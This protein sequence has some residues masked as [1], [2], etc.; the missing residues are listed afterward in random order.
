M[1]FPADPIGPHHRQGVGSRPRCT[2]LQQQALLPGVGTG[3]G[4]QVHVQ[5]FGYIADDQNHQD[6]PD[7]IGQGVP[8]ADVFDHL[9]SGGLTQ[10]WHQT[11]SHRILSGR[12]GRRAGERPRHQASIEA[13]GKIENTRQRKGQPQ[14]DQ[15]HDQRQQDVFLTIFPKRS[16]KTG[17]G[18]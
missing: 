1:T 17:S 18:L 2:A 3:H 16:E 5:Q 13:W 14:P 7:Q 8:H 10:P 9:C 15:G 12:Q 4:L 11:A 6:G